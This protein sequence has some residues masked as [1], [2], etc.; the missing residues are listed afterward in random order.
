[1]EERKSRKNESYQRHL[2]EHPAP[3]TG[4]HHV[5]ASSF[6]HNTKS[7]SRDKKSEQSFEHKS[8]PGNSKT[9]FSHTHTNNS[10]VAKVQEADLYHDSQNN[11]MVAQRQHN[12]RQ[13]TK[14]SQ[15]STEKADVNPLSMV[16]HARP[17]TALTNQT[18]YGQYST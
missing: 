18:A 12:S 17:K 9:Q 7:H 4:A 1:M 3:G 15:R 13:G 10:T 16:M 8:Q 5:Y 11:S 2:Q 14:P 6:P